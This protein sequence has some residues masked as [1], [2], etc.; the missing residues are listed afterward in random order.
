[1]LT[2]RGEETDRLRGLESGADDY[3]VKPFSP[4]ELV[5]RTKAILRRGAPIGERFH[6]GSLELELT[7]RIVS[8]EGA[9]LN[10]TQIEGC[11]L[12]LGIL[13]NQIAFQMSHT[14]N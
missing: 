12:G 6:Y 11:V 7:N 9:E 2:A 8:L 3:L 13:F 14:A 1:M 10:L 4:R 5:A